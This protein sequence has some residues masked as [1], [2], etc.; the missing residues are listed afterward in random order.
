M[1]CLVCERLSIAYLCRTCRDRLLAPQPDRRVLQDGLVV[2]SFYGYES[3]EPLLQAKYHPFGS[4]VLRHLARSSLRPFFRDLAL[5]IQAALIAID[6]RPGEHFSH[7][8]VLARHA[9]CRHLP[10]HPGRLHAK[11][12]VQYA[13][14]DL[15]FRRAHPRNFSFRPFKEPAAILIDDVITTGSTLKEAASVLQK[16]QKS[17]LF[18]TVLADADRA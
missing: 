3:I 10:Y 5:D 13:G 6:D 18:A 7:T 12:R 16:H 8:A 4:R 2:F 17:A 1:R 11:N 9:R 14:R 15:A